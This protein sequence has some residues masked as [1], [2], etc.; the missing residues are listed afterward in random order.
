M[1]CDV[2]YASDSFGCGL[3]GSMLTL[4]A[5]ATC[6]VHFHVVTP[7]GLAIL[8]RGINATIH[9]LPTTPPERNL[10]HLQ[11]HPSTNARYFFPSY[12]N[13]SRALYID[14]DTL[15]D[16]DISELF[17]MDMKGATVACHAQEWQ[18]LKWWNNGTSIAGI[19]DSRQ[20]YSAGVVLV[21]VNEWRK[22]NWTER[23]LDLAANGQG[24]GSN[25]DQLVFNVIGA[26]DDAI[27]PFEDRWH[28]P[29]L[30]CEPTR[31]NDLYR[32]SIPGIHHWCC[33][34]KWWL[35]RG[36]NQLYAMKLIDLLPHDSTMCSLPL[37][38]QTRR[39]QA[40]N[41]KLWWIIYVIGVCTFCYAIW[42]RRDSLGTVC[43]ALHS[44]CCHCHTTYV[45]VR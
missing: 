36:D 8:P 25:D 30:G 45:R 27:I 35:P 21:D 23:L 9:K 44:R 19:P 14:T 26:R 16:G 4:L 38:V 31:S 2:V 37:R 40:Q 18:T 15:I 12:V 6:D 34:N 3:W 43:Y 41:T 13:V 24:L 1:N 17:Q 29:C 42:I 22:H 7:D 20:L 39:L 11:G 33:A 5:H 10:N 28:G 32:R